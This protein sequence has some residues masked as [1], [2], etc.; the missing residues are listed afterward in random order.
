MAQRQLKLGLVTT[1]VGGPGESN[2]WLDP[3][4][5]LDASVDIDW[6]ITVVRQAEEAK[7]DLVFIV[8]SQ[9]ITKDS[10]P[11]Y[12][13]RLEPLTL[14][15]ALAVATTHIGLVGT[16]TT[17]Y[18]APFNLARRLASL[19]LISKGRAGWN[20]VTSGDSGTAGNYGLDEHFDYDTRYGRAIE[21]IDVV[22]GLWS[23]YEEDAFV[24]DRSTGV[25]LDPT[26][27]HALNHKGQYFSVKG[28]LNIQR[29]PQ[30]EPV[31]FQAGDS[32]QGRNLGASVADA[33]FTHARSIEEG[34]A[35]YQDI[36]GRALRLG[37]NP[38][39]IVILPGFTLYVGD[40]DDEAR[41]LEQHYRRLDQSFEQSLAEFG[42]AFGWH[43]FRQYDLDQPF[44]V[45]ALTFAKNSFYTQAK[46]LTDLALSRDFTLRQ[47]V[48][49]VRSSRLSPFV[50]APETV[51][52]EIIRWFEGRALDGLNVHLGHPSQFTRFT[53]EVLPI[54]QER[55]V[56]RR[57][58]E[59]T[60]L[61]GNLGLEKPRAAP[62][63]MPTERWPVSVSA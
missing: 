26:R 21:Y 34:Q 50:G 45:E 39:Q 33:I 14:L 12:L 29:S 54:L 7:F 63:S 51:A 15:S 62:R 55:G 2:R 24:R 36:K 27:L 49:F 43:D 48:E 5:P 35:F 56:F 18:N 46:R 31:I 59:D 19:D 6:Y 60:T 37:R 52:N 20:V 53:T 38:D 32:D 10:P 25:F 9:Y 41:E 4:I 1:G 44:P 11:H 8:D 30:G 17:S 57:E 40:T 47:T 61:R 3:D 28:P 22:R 13:N 16:L 42:R 58:Y 23:S